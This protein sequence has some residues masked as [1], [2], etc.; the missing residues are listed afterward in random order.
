M[1]RN[2]STVPNQVIYFEDFN[3][4]SL[5]NSPLMGTRSISEERDLIIS[6]EIK[7]FYFACLVIFCKHFGID[8]NF[9]RDGTIKMSKR[10]SPS[11]GDVPWAHPKV[12]NDSLMFATQ[13]MGNG[14]YTS[15]WWEIRRGIRYSF[16]FFIW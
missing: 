15:I 6:I 11:L 16:Q 7:Q 12:T 14:D 2:G 9:R 13:I 1:Y 10:L 5:H 8:D 4:Q 3:H